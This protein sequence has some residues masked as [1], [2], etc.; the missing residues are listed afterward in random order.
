[1]QRP[2]LILREVLSVINRISNQAAVSG[3][4]LVNLLPTRPKDLWPVIGDVF[5]SPAV[6]FRSYHAVKTVT[7]GLGR[8]YQNC[9][10]GRMQ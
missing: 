4:T 5:T 8:P 6:P 7:S 10:C 2:V 3:N 1:M 9:E